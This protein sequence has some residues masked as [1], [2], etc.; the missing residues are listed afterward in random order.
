MTVFGGQQFRPLLHVR[1]VGLAIIAALDVDASGAFNLHCENITIVELAEK[2][3]EKYPEVKLTITE[4]SFQDSRNY[5]VSSDK[6]LR[7][8]GFNP[9]FSVDFGISEVGDAL[10]E[11][12]FPKIL[13][14][15]F[16]NADMMRQT[17]QLN[18]SPLLREV[19][20]N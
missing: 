12:R 15:S 5:A 7:I 2:I 9:R 19:Y 18:E 10:R 20:K 4:Q 6:A 8:F 17:L 11:G 1:D 14:P 16:S 13:D 3:V